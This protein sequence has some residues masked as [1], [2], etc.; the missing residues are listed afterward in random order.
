[1]LSISDRY[2]VCLFK[3]ILLV[4]THTCHHTLDGNKEAYE[5]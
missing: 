1:M 5:L 4:Y 3:K 2:A